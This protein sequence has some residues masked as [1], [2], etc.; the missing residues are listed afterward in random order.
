MKKINPDYDA[1]DH[2]SAGISGISPDDIRA[3][4][5]GAFA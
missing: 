1:G 2:A 5:R 3:A 4:L